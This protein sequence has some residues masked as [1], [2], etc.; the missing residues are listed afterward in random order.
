MG[1]DPVLQL[2]WGVELVIRSGVRMAGR[3]H[4]KKHS[5]NTVITQ[6]KQGP[7]RESSM[8]LGFLSITHS[9]LHHSHCLSITC[10]LSC[11]SYPLIPPRA[12]GSCGN[13]LF[14]TVS[15]AMFALASIGRAVRAKG[16][17]KSCYLLHGLDEAYDPLVA[18][19]WAD[20]WQEGWW[21]RKSEKV[22]K[23][24][25]FSTSWQPHK[26]TGTQRKVAC[27]TNVDEKIWH[28]HNCNVA[29]PRSTLKSTGIGN[30]ET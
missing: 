23:R 21:Q 15:N 30:M 19:R 27:Y 18:S 8:S 1:P 10:I 14:P 17:T 20:L 2:H 9:N 11:C 22:F 3:Q 6:R 29:T 28:G 7:S 25:W 4:S 16:Y 24:C 13:F 12:C 26:W 5:H